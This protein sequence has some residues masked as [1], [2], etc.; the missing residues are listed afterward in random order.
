MIISNAFLD[1]LSV[2][3]EISEKAL[4]AAWEMMSLCWTAGA[5]NQLLP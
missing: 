5:E 4:A 3:S 1:D 2:L